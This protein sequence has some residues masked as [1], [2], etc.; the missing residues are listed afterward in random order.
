M[1]L[2]QKSYYL[3]SYVSWLALHSSGLRFCCLLACLLVRS[4]ARLLARS[5]TKLTLILANPAKVIKEK[6]KSELRVR[7]V[8][9]KKKVK[10]EDWA[11]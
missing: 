11:R 5:L 8:E 4:L 7:G 6:K 9:T 1:L 10:K 2:R 3:P